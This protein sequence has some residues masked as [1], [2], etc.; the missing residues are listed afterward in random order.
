[1]RT[2]NRNLDQMRD[3]KITPNFIP[4]ADGSVLIECGQTRIICTASVENKVPPFRTETG[5]GWV[6][7][8]YSMLPGS[9]GRRKARPILKQDGRSIEI[10]RLIGRSLRSVVDMKKLRDK[11][12]MVDCDVI[13]ADGGTRTA[14]ITGG[15][16]ALVLA[17]DKLM[18]EGELNSSP[19]KSNVAAVSVGIVDGQVMLD[20]CY[21]ED[22]RA[23]TDMNVVMLGSGEFVEVQGTAE[24][25][26][27]TRDEMNQ[28]LDFAQKGI[29]ELI[30]LQKSIING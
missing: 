2:D 24:G 21:K 15:Y 20:L 4:S 19:I 6:S 26:A 5:L 18:S 3:V 30:E 14:S 27:F 7:A 25:K 8:E 9:T 11:T 1:M 16:I 23:Q 28:A 13:Q 22:S 17:V 10:Q 29:E 12:I